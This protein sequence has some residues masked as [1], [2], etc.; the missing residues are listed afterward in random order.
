MCVEYIYICVAYKDAVFHCKVPSVVGLYKGT[1]VIKSKAK[2]KKCINLRGVRH[3]CGQVQEAC[4]K[5]YYCKSCVPHYGKPKE[6]L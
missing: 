1:V 4:V 6:K 2:V 5:V 3:V